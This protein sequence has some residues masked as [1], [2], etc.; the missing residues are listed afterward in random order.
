[1]GEEEVEILLTHH[2]PLRLS[3]EDHVLTVGVERQF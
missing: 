1:M 3:G 2:V